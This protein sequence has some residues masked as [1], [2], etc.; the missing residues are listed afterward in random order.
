MIIFTKTVYNSAP[1][2]ENKIKF[3]NMSHNIL[4]AN[5]AIFKENLFK[6]LSKFSLEKFKF[7]ILFMKN[8]IQNFKIKIKFK[9]VWKLQGS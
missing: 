7:E 9:S 6:I 5:Y 1:A 2:F 4:L 3:S 8:S